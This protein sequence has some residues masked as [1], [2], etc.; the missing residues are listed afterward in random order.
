MMLFFGWNR[1]CLF[2]FYWRPSHDHADECVP[3]DWV[4]EKAIQV[5][6]GSIRKKPPAPELAC[7]L[8]VRQLEE[9]AALRGVGIEFLEDH[10]L[11]VGER[12]FKDGPKRRFHVQ[13]KTALGEAL[14]IVSRIGHDARE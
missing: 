3:L 11:P 13:R 14:D 9:K 5:R 2:D 8:R 7:L 10:F 6:V 1:I 12:M 4:V